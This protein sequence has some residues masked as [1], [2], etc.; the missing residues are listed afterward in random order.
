MRWRSWEAR[1]KKPRKYDRNR[2][3]TV[4]VWNEFIIFLSNFLP[5][6]TL[7]SICFKGWKKGIRWWFGQHFPFT[8][9]QRGMTIPLPR[10]E[11]TRR[12]INRRERRKKCRKQTQGCLGTNCRATFL[13]WR[14]KWRCPAPLPYQRCCRQMERTHQAR[15]PFSNP[16][17]VLK[18]WI[19]H[20][21]FHLKNVLLIQ[22]ARHT[23]HLYMHPRMRVSG[24]HENRKF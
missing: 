2:Q 19:N 6:I 18:M 7:P 13:H 10:M 21:C 16:D 14:A 20:S 4:K 24:Y 12:A 9:L 8:L 15:Q 1:R 3:K 23:L 22:V 11:M 17:Q 5:I